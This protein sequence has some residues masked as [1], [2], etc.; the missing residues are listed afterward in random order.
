MDPFANNLKFTISMNVNS[1]H[2]KP[3]F[4]HSCRGPGYPYSFSIKSIISFNSSVEI[5]CFLA[6]NATSSLYELAK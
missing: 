1:D 4:L 6:K 2:P 3:I 5:F